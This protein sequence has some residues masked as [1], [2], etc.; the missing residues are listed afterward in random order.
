MTMVPRATRL[1]DDK[2]E[3]QFPFNQAFID[4]L[5][6]TIPHPHRKWDP[7]RRVWVV[8]PGYTE[9]AI[10]LL[11][12]AFPDAIVTNPEHVTPP[13]THRFRLSEP[14]QV[15]YVSI[16]APRCVVDAAYRALCKEL[17]P[18]RAPADKRDEMHE[19]QVALN[20]AYEAIRDRIAS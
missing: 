12:S 13:R 5:R 7:Q 8:G 3:L 4:L 16:D 1:W 11:R 20:R 14:H 15:L 2:W 17:H 9:T 18:D 10:H 6:S 19:E